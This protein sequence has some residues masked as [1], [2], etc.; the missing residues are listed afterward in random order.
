MTT[1]VV[2][3][4]KLTDEVKRNIE[5]VVW[6]YKPL[7]ALKNQTGYVWLDET[8]ANKLVASGDVQSMDEGILNFKEIEGEKATTETK[9]KVTK[10][11]KET[12]KTTK[13]V[14]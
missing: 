14:K 11:V 2:K 8:K 12:S 10:D 7:A 3:N 13:S 9:A 5:T 4:E 6:A 1:K